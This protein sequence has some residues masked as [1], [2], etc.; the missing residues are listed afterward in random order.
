MKGW[1]GMFSVEHLR[2]LKRRRQNRDGYH[3][4]KEKYLAE[5][6]YLAA[7]AWANSKNT[8]KRRLGKRAC[9]KIEA[10]ESEKQVIASISEE[11]IELATADMNSDSSIFLV[12]IAGEKGTRFA[13]KTANEVLE[14]LGI[15][16]E[17]PKNI[18]I[19][20]VSNFGSVREL[21]SS[22]GYYDDFCEHEIRCCG[23]RW[24][25]ARGESSLE[26]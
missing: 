13:L 20:D 12:Q 23:Y 8:I 17:Q 24:N 26:D 21:Y 14:L 5:F 9:Q 1:I 19:Y 18:K 22:Q 3:A 2:E 4:L 6:A 10:G 16:R 11:Y 7:E 15:S 25:L